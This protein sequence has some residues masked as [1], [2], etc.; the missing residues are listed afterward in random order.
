MTTLKQ[1]FSEH[2]ICDRI[3]NDVAVF[4]VIEWLQQKRKYLDVT[5]GLQRYDPIKELLE[6]LEHDK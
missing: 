4:A 6:E 2:G 3:T 1:I 5:S